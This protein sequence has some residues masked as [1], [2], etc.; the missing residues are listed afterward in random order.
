MSFLKSWK[1]LKKIEGDFVDDAA[2]SGGATRFGITEKVARAD[3]YEGPMEE[4]SSR[5]AMHIAK[6]RYWDV[7]LLDQVEGI[8]PAVAHEMFDTGYNMGNAVAVKMLQRSLNAFNNNATHYHDLKVDGVMGGITLNALQLFVSRRRA[9]GVTVLL[10]ALNGLQLERY[11][12][13]AE[14]RP[15]DERFVYGWVLNR[16][17]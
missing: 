5:R 4:L 8:S 17:S 3:G 12:S 9:E 2:D 15:K 7:M 6:R 11:F 16:V 14:R 1:H 10:R 13:I